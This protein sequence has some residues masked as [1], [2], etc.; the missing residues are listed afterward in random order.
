MAGDFYMYDPRMTAGVNVT[1]G[2]ID[3]DGYADIIT[4]PS[5]GPAHLRAVSGRALAA[6]QGPEDLI[7]TI[8]WTGAA[9]GLRVAAVDSDGDGR[10]DLVASTGGANAGRIALFAPATLLP[11]NPAGARWLD[12]FPGLGGSL[13]VG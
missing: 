11:A 2:D 3:G 1:V 10:V 5:S 7:S 12:P 9:T 6:G 4:G 8:L 13:F